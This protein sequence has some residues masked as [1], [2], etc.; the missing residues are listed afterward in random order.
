MQRPREGRQ[1]V[2]LRGG[3]KCWWLDRGFRGEQ[4]EMSVKD[5]MGQVLPNFCAALWDLDL[6]LWAMEPGLEKMDLPF[7]G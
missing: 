5:N 4:K 7:A 3:R 6:T 1:L 2:C